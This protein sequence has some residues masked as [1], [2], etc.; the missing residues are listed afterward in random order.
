M[1]STLGAAFLL[2]LAGMELDMRVLSERPLL[3]AIA[4]SST[5]VGIVIP[6]LRDTGT[7]A[8]PTGRFTVA[9]ASVAEFATIAMLALFFSAKAS[10]SVEAILVVVICL[11]SSFS[12]H[13]RAKVVT[14]KLDDSSSQ[15][16]VRLAVVI[17]SWPDEDGFRHKVEGMG[18]GFF[19]FL[20]AIHMMLAVNLGVANGA[21]R[22]T[23]GSL[24]I[25]AGLLSALVF[26]V[27][28]QKLLAK[29][30]R[31]AVP[32]PAEGRSQE[33]L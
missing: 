11:L 24:L 14:L 1:M 13:S 5:S 15:V 18:F 3:V 9:G 21:M 31:A 17:R 32:E 10:P 29:E 8:T 4:L 33:G 20:L 19:V 2:F 12:N 16:R 30:G 22:P 27:L 7:I 28:A 26:P 23:T 25:A 6:V